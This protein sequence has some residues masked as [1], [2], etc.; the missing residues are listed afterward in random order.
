MLEIPAVST[1]NV[2]VEVRARSAGA[3]HDP[4]GGTVQMA[5][6]PGTV[7]PE[8]ADW[9]DA[10]W[11]VDDTDGSPVYRALCLVGP[12][13]DAALVPDTWR[14]WVRVQAGDETPVRPAGFIKIY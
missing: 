14:V 7:A 10:T 6:L 3:A 4:T 12:G 5:F 1:E 8:E 11:E 9:V 13:T 2:R